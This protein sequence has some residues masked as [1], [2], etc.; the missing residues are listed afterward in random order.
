MH[1]CHC[2]CMVD[3]EP[4]YKYLSV[5]LLSTFRGLSS[6]CENTLLQLLLNLLPRSTPNPIRRHPRLLIPIHKKLHRNAQI[7]RNLY[8]SAGFELP[9]NICIPKEK[10]RTLEDIAEK[11]GYYH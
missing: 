6:P 7:K 11:P 2:Y 9:R 8:D 10:I 5:S 3:R 1:R 4:F